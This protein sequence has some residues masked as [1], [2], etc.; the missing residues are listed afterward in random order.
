[1][2]VEE[3]WLPVV[4]FELIY[5]VS[6]NGRVRRERPIR[7]LRV[8]VAGNQRYPYLV[9]SKNGKQTTHRV[10]Q[11]VMRAFIGPC[12]DGMEINHKNGNKTDNRLENLEYITRLENARHGITV[13]GKHHVGEKHPMA[14]LSSEQVGWI[15]RIYRHGQLTQKQLGAAFGVC[16]STIG[17]LVT[18]MT[19]RT[20]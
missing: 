17:Y 5:S 4:G 15:R 20:A 1:M 13:L 8:S 6:T 18:G 14:K 12:P 2:I 16:Q 19:W 3:K 10:H 7:R 11:L 9:L